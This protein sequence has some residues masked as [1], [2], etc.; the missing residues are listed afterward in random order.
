MLQQVNREVVAVLETAGRPLVY[1]DRRRD[2]WSYR[3]ML[4]DVAMR[5]RINRVETRDA[6]AEDRP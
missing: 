2:Q 6:V 1:I 4:C 3:A 5:L